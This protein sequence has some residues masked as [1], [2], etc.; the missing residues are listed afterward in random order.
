MGA[1]N[2]MMMLNATHER[3]SWRDFFLSTA[4]MMTFGIWVAIQRN[5]L[6]RR[7][8]I[9]TLLR[10]ARNLALGRKKET[11][12]QGIKKGEPNYGWYAALQVMLFVEFGLAM[13]PQ[14]WPWLSRQDTNF[15]KPAV[16]M[17]ALAATVLSWKYVK[18]SNQSAARAMAAEIKKAVVA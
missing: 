1:F 17:T 9:E 18:E 6:D 4:P 7:S 10:H 11:L 15:A 12:P 8:F 3:G 2:G 5:A 13:I 16:A 14:V